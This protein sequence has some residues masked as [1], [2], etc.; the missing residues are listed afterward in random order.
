MTHYRDI[1]DR[2]ACGR[3]A[4]Q[5]ELAGLV[6]LAHDERVLSYAQGLARE[7]RTEWYGRGVYIRGLVEISNRCS[8]GCYY[9]GLRTENRSLERYELSED[10]ILAACHEGYALGLRSFVLQGGERRNITEQTTA[11]VRRIKEELPDVALTLSLGEQTES[12]YEAWRQAGADRYLLRH[13]SATPSHYAMLHPERMSWKG[14]VECL[15]LLSRLGYQR[16]AGF[17]VGTPGQSEEMLAHEVDFLRDMRPEMVGI[18]P[19]LPQSDTPFG[20]MPSGDV[21]TTLMML[22]LVRVALPKALMPATTALATTAGEGTQ[23]GVLSGANVVMPN[24]TPLLYRASYAIYDG[25]KSSGTES[26]EGLERLAEELHS[27]GY[28][29]VMSRGDHP[30]FVEK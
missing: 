15:Q 27:I 8:Q 7:V 14:R 4:S 3:E 2:L 6:S 25:K 18:G 22:A 20:T 30:D 12:T 5:E 26:A 24:I 23:L 11:V 16:G 19:F 17:M 9:C 1:L 29:A 10:E 21:A 28:E 13:E